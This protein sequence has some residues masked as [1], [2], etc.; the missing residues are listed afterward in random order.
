MLHC[1]ADERLES[2]QQRVGALENIVGQLEERM[3]ELSAAAMAAPGMSALELGGGPA[4]E[5]VVASNALR[6]EWKAA[7]AELSTTRHIMASLEQEYKDAREWQAGIREG[8]VE[9]G[10]SASWCQQC[11]RKH[12]HSATSA[13]CRTAVCC[14]VRASSSSFCVQPLTLGAVFSLTLVSTLANAP[15]LAAGAAVDVEHARYAQVE[16]SLQFLQ[17]RLEAAEEAGAGD[18]ARYQ[19][20]T[21]EL[22]DQLQQQTSEL[23]ECQHRCVHAWAAGCWTA[24]HMY[25]CLVP[26]VVGD[27]Q[28]LLASLR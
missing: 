25:A 15:P 10:E 24:Q 11:I 8:Q 2:E 9:R 13:A 26:W 14:A 3:T 12:W 27:Y 19:N 4:A 21:A 28:A 17:E 5:L 22:H 16:A 6:K 23:V 20:T 1:A 18:E 7:T